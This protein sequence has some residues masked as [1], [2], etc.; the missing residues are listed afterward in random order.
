MS[1][2]WIIAAACA[3]FVKGLC[4]FANTL[5]FTSIMSF[6]VDNVNI[7]PV[8]I[9]LTYPSNLLLVIK[10]RKHIKHKVVLPLCALVLAGCVPGILLLKNVDTGAIKILFGIAI[11]LIGIEMLLREFKSKKGSEQKKQSKIILLGIGL[12]SGILSGLSDIGALLSADI[13]RVTEGIH[14][15]KANICTVFFVEGTF[16]IIM[17]AI[18]GGVLT[19]DAANHALRLS[20]VMLV[21]M[22]LGMFSG[23]FLNEKTVKK[24]VILLLIISGAALII[25]S[26]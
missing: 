4:G 24:L 9:V 20:P 15:I 23:K 5:V 6:T 22:M 25:N 12:L 19:L 17:Y 10:E 2:W 26:I 18:I 16:R 8:E 3:F 13:S 14:E 21:S 11:I 7:S 1:F